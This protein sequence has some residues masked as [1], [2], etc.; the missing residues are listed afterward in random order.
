[1]RGDRR[2]SALYEDARAIL[3]DAGTTAGLAAAM[4]NLG[5]VR[6]L[7]GETDDAQ[8]LFEDALVIARDT[9]DIPETAK[10][11]AEMSLIAIG[12]DDIDTAQAYLE[13]SVEI[14]T[15]IGN[16]PGAA[17]C[18][19]YLSEIARRRGDLRA[20]RDHAAQALATWRDVG[21]RLGAAGQLMTLAEISRDEADLDGARRQARTA[22]EEFIELDAAHGVASALECLA[23]VVVHDD[24]RLT[25]QL[26]GAA[27]A[28][29]DEM[30]AESADDP[31]TRAARDRA[32]HELGAEFDNLLE[33]GKRLTPRDA[34]ALAD[35]GPETSISG[36]LAAPC[37]D[38]RPPSTRDS[39]RHLLHGVAAPGG[40]RTVIS[41]PRGFDHLVGGNG[42]LHPVDAVAVGTT[43]SFSMTSV[44]PAPLS[45]RRRVVTIAKW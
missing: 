4:A 9:G 13:E 21:H 32:R 38:M 33:A 5:M 17:A 18:H 28:V 45:T 31:S 42:E 3:T 19:Y 41:P 10:I 30:G 11:L 44:T 37:E 7:A 16:R 14:T 22:L 15:R 29:R 39:Y 35:V 12:A 34:A 36:S 26:L 20:A 27:G 2:R 1:M 40:S 24:T 43:R 6:R 25:A 23:A 8:K